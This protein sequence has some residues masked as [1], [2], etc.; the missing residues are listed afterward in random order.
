LT[1]NFVGAN[2]SDPDGIIAGY[3][4]DFGD[5]TSSTLAN[6]SKTYQAAGN[7]T[8]TLT[9]TD[10]AGA[11]AAASLL[12]AVGSTPPPSTAKS[13]NVSSLTLS[14]VKSSNTTGY[15]SGVVTI[16]DQAGK[17]VPNAA[18]TVEA[19]GL[20]AGTV[21]AKTN[22]KGQVTI[23]TPK[24][25]SSTTGSE[26]YTVKNVVLSGYTYDPAKNKVTSATLTR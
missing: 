25:S 17:V 3:L 5:G 15:I 4:W 2:S 21:T 8:A 19:T 13:V 23:N 1:V 9:V 12:I 16:V 18:V 22:S 6:V 26:T 10:N 11:T 24:L 14:W 20:V 7:Y